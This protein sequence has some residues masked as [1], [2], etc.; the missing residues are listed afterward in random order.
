MNFFLIYIIRAYEYIFNADMH[1]FL[2]LIKYIQ[3]KCN[4]LALTLYL[5]QIITYLMLYNYK[6]FLYVVIL[7]YYIE[8]G[9]FYGKIK[10]FTGST[11]K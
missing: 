11:S 4:H 10:Q 9:I 2:M 8:K 5:F 1:T 7:C 3:T 6:M